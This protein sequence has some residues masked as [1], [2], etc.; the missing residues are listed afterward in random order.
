MYSSWTPPGRE[1]PPGAREGPLYPAGQRDADSRRKGRHE[2][3]DGTERE[4]EDRGEGGGARRRR[5]GKGK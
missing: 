5:E 3:Q 4:Q 2:A 1:E